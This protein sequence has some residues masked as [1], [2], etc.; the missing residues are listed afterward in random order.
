MIRF[1]VYGIPVPKGSRTLGVRRDGST[2]SRPA[3]AGE[4][5][6][7]EAVARTAQ[8]RRA[9]ALELPEAGELPEPPYAVALAFSCRRPARPAHAHPSLHDL[10][11][12]CRAAL[13]G[14]VR[15]GLLVDD[16]HVVDLR[17]TKAWATAPGGEGVQ[18]TI[19]AAEALAPPSPR[20]APAGG[21]TTG[22]GRS[23]GARRAQ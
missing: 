13:D 20:I 7:V 12:L 3:S 22:S 18:V 9:Q 16:R 11:K 15:D 19:S 14:L 21:A 4:H 6:W 23:H 5:G 10:D 2:Y 8:W 1:M 17:A